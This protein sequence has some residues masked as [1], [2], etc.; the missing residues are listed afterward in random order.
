MCE[1]E[2]QSQFD[3][4]PYGAALLFDVT[5]P[6]ASK[7]R[8]QHASLADTLSNDGF[9]IFISVCY[10]YVPVMFSL[11]LVAR[12][13][14]C[15]G[16]RELCLAVLVLSTFFLNELVLKHFLSQP[17]PEQSCCTSCGMPSSHSAFALS[18]WIFQLMDLSWRLDFRH[19]SWTWRS[20][21]EVFK[22]PWRHWDVFTVQQFLVLCFAWSV[23]MLPVPASRV[24][25]GDHSMSQV[26]AGGAVGCLMGMALWFLARLAQLRQNHHVGQKLSIQ[27]LR[28]LSHNMALPYPEMLRYPSRAKDSELQYYIE[29]MSRFLSHQNLCDRT[30]GRLQEAKR[31]LELALYR[32]RGHVT[33]EP[34]QDVLRTP[35]APLLCSGFGRSRASSG[36]VAGPPGDAEASFLLSSKGFSEMRQLQPCCDDYEVF[37]K[38]GLRVASPFSDH[39]PEQFPLRFVFKIRR[40]VDDPAEFEKSLQLCRERCDHFVIYHRQS[41]EIC[42][43]RDGDTPIRRFR[44]RSSQASASGS[45]GIAEPGP[46]HREES[47]DVEATMSETEMSSREPASQEDAADPQEKDAQRSETS[48]A[49]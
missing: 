5:W 6:D 37:D 14:V 1:H 25:L 26:L 3:S 23:L 32:N 44:I 8:S 19:S 45:G 49:R 20:V 39:R 41:E 10:S 13:C 38:D 17:R 15:R 33:A 21:S 2:W 11:S 28:V 24:N 42:F 46:M 9:W 12:I 43:W 4:C 34:T 48:T 16:T 18:I 30:R 7:A 47:L 31:L 35:T 27:G 36:E 22:S 29:E 40:P